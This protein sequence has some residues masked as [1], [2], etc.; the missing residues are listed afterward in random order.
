VRGARATRPP[1][2]VAFRSQP[3]RAAFVPLVLVAEE[4]G[5]GRGGVSVELRLNM[6]VDVERD[7]RRRMSEPLAHD[8]GMD[9]GL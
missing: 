1:R 8:L 2:D 3:R 9:T 5:D 4:F 7:S 6:A